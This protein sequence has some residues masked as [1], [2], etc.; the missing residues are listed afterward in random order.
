MNNN[1]S[2][3]TYTLDENCKIEVDLDSKV[4]TP[5]GT[6]EIIIESVLSYL[7]EPGNLLDLG[8]GSGLVG[9]AI[10]KAG[11]VQDKLYASDLSNEAVNLLKK[12]AIKNEVLCDARQGSIYEPWN[13]HK[14]DYIID[15]IS[16]VAKQV[17]SISSW[18]NK[19]SC[20]AGTDGTS[21]VNQAINKQT[22]KKILQETQKYLQNSKLFKRHFS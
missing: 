14:F 8:C 13:G 20:E 15:D 17:A 1:D 9:L 7:D 16:G 5:T 21:L 10:Y 4:F 3:F 18:F 19:T 12:N 2:S 6:S 11:K 22:N